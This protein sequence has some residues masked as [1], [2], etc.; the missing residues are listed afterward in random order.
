MMASRNEM[1]GSAARA[2]RRL[3]AIAAAAACAMS[4]GGC[5]FAPI[6][7]Q[8][9]GDVAQLRDVRIEA[10]ENSRI[11]YVF[12]QVMADEL[13][14]YQPSGD[15]VLMAFLSENRQGF[16]IRVDDVAT[17][18]ESSVTAVYRLVRQSDGKVLTSGRRTGVA[19]YDVTNDPYAELSSE[20]RAIDRAVEQVA[21]KVRLDLTLYFANAPDDA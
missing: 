8:P 19:S 15:F 18:Y 6:Y 10:Q 21:E 4:L 7:A 2:F 3:A 11:D 1:T 16:G 20:G 17:R 14:A 12:Q 13:G 9:G 5:G